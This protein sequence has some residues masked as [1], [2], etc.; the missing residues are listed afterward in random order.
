MRRLIAPVLLLVMV[1]TS[2]S[3]DDRRV[4]TR[5]GD[6]P[7]PSEPQD[8]GGPVDGG[9]YVATGITDAGVDRP[10]VEGTELRITFDPVEGEADALPQMTITAGCNTLGASYDVVGD[11]LRVSDVFGTEMACEPELMDQDT[12][13]SEV[14]TGEVGW[15]TDGDTL[16]L[17]SGDV[18]ITLVP[19]EV[20]SPDLD[21]VGPS[22]VLDTLVDGEAASTV[23]AGVEATIT[24]T[25]DGT[26]ALAAGCNTGGG[27]WSAEGDELRLTATR[28]TRMACGGDA[29]AVERAVL[30]VIDDTVTVDITEDRLT[31]TTADGSA[32]LGFTPA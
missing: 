21:L 16:T 15:S 19:R 5:S 6:D 29:G 10:L 25:D 17:T 31:L 11:T 8:A 3:D 12:W 32:G 2:C 26:F 14:L 18:E 9:E 28:L 22:W 30:G 13:L 23:P 4:G 20:A 27:A 24:F 7:P 1:L